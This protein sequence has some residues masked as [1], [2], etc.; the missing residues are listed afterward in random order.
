LVALVR[1]RPLG[2]ATILLALGPL[3]ILAHGWIDFV[4]RNPAILGFAAALAL[5]SLSLARH[6]RAAPLSVST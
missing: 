5:L 4:L 2:F 3:L 6:D 1:L